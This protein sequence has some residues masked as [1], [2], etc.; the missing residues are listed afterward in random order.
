MSEQQL[1]ERL[2]ITLGKPWQKHGYRQAI[3]LAT[4]AL[5][6]VGGTV[7]LTLAAALVLGKAALSRAQFETDEALLAS[8]GAPV[9]LVHA[10]EALGETRTAAP[11]EMCRA[12]LQVVAACCQDDI[13]RRKLLLD[14]ERSVFMT[15]LAIHGEHGDDIL[16]EAVSC[17]TSVAAFAPG[18]ASRAGVMQWAIDLMC[19]EDGAVTPS[20]KVRPRT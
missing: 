16:S 20:M 6:S 15:A 19:R 11:V 4:T 17:V 5:R 2:R 18:D 1:L 12:A 3:D 9:F 10:V 8:S 14:P 7:D 13:T